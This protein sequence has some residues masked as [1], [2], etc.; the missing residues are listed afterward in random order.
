MTMNRASLSTAATILLLCGG[1]IQADDGK[2]EPAKK[3]GPQQPPAASAVTK[4]EAVSSPEQVKGVLLEAVKLIQTMAAEAARREA[5]FEM[6]SPADFA[7]RFTKDQHADALRAIGRAQARLGDLPAARTSWQL[8]LDA[9]AAVS[10]LNSSVSR[11]SDRTSLF[12]GIAED[13]IEA[14]ERDEVR[15]TLRQALQAT[16]TGPP[17]L[18]FPMPRPPAMDF[19]EDP[20]VKKAESLRR[21]AQLQAKVGET[22]PSAETLRLALEA[23]DSIKVPLNKVHELVAIAGGVPPETARV[24]WA[25]ALEV[26][27]AQD[28]YPRSLGVG[29]ILRARVK[30]GEIDQALATIT[31]HLKGDLH[32]Y[33]L[34]VIADALASSDEAIPAKSA[35]RLAQLAQKAEYDRPSK[36]LKVYQRIAE[37]QARLGEYEA[38][39]RTIGEPQ[40]KDNAQDFQATLAR[41]KVMH[42]VASAQLKANRRDASKD[43]VYA[44]LELC[45]PL[46]F[47]DSE[48]VLPLAT[49]GHLLAEAGDFRGAFEIV[50]DLSRGLSKASYLAEIATVQARDKRDADARATMRRAIE[51]GRRMPN[52]AM[53]GRGLNS[54]DNEPMTPVRRSIALAQARIGDLDAAFKTISEMGQAQF[55]IF[56]RKELV[57]QIVAMR[58]EAD[59]VAGARRA[60][61]LI[62]PSDIMFQ[63]DKVDLLERIVKRQARREDPAP[64]LDGARKQTTPRA[65]L[66]LIRGLAEGIAERFDTKAKPSKPADPSGRAQPTPDGP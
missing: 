47:E 14:G 61:D 44:A 39:Y 7:M 45:A 31:D 33:G 27:M 20:T 23:A 11:T 38:A 6:Q 43:T 52:D 42:A 59:D 64:L 5:Q 8:A 24:T 46:A 21:I 13:Q 25:K 18:P 34:W 49:L 17:E 37:V 66:Q 32:T 26:A 53:W 41:I 19:A 60:V 51:A 28:E 9:T 3:A 29:A 12:I 22:A 50:D 4:P 10:F 62:P 36:K 16:R 48:M 55:A 56:A 54:P 15:F 63:D 65:R 2:T 57:D 35:E 58:L 1:R 30:G 40:P